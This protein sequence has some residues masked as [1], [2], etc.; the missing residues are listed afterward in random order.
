V[1]QIER[2]SRP[3]QG[4]GPGP[5]PALPL[6]ST[7]RHTA[8]DTAQQHAVAGRRDADASTSDA[9]AGAH[10]VEQSIVRI[11]P[12]S[13]LNLSLRFFRRMLLIGIA[14][15]V[16]GW[17]VAYVTGLAGSID[18]FIQDLSGYPSLTIL[19]FQ[20]L[21]V[22]IVLGLTFVLGGAL[23]A[24]LGVAVFNL[25]SDLSGGI[26]MT[27]METDLDESLLGRGGSEAPTESES[28]GPRPRANDGRALS[29]ARRRPVL[30]ANVTTLDGHADPGP[31]GSRRDSADGGSPSTP[32]EQEDRPPRVRR[33]ALVVGVERDSPADS[34]GLTTGDVIVSVDGTTVDS[35]AA[36]SSA[37]SRHDADAAFDMSWVDQQ[38]R[39]QT[40]I[41]H[42]GGR[43]R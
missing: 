29:A 26:K 3:E 40:A 5:P 25:A 39:Y 23:L 17:I 32:V 15:G 21:L 18:T 8:Q 4:P 41:V 37:I 13:V 28:S 42:V 16:V 34:V 43:S 11:D 9:D 35:P 19:G 27:V 30:G 38:G 24:V 6:A 31:A 14:V 2:V 22:A 33:G 36:L 1:S 7:A 20:G 12:R 10:R